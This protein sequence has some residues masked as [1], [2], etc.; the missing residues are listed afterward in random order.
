MRR[1]LPPVP[2]KLSLALTTKINDFCR[3]LFGSE[4][5]RDVFP[6]QVRR[7]PTQR[8]YTAGEVIDLALLP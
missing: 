4:A 7:R 8:L 3:W 6:R 5:G 2:L 1:V